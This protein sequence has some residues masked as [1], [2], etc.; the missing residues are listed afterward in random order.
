MSKVVF[1]YEAGRP[2]NY[3]AFAQW[4]FYI[5]PN[6]KRDEKGRCHKEQALATIEIG[7]DV[8]R[9]VAEQLLNNAERLDFIEVSQWLVV[10]QDKKRIN[11]KEWLCEPR[12]EKP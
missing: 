11:H 1:T 12:I 2:I 3:R 5:T 7:L 6:L 8:S 9:S 4:L 10:S